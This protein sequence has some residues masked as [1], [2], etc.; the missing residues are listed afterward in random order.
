MAGKRKEV[1]MGFTLKY[2][3][4]GTTQTERI[5]SCYQSIVR[6][7]ELRSQGYKVTSIK[8][9]PTLVVNEI[10]KKPLKSSGKQLT[11]NFIEMANGL[12]K[13]RKFGVRER[14]HW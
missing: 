4:D 10:E 11:K 12:S 1:E 3:K 14:G 9:K 7:N 13:S 5:S 8:D 6:A 2:T